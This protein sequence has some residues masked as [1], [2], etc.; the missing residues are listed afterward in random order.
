M[1]MPGTA[2][3]CTHTPHTTHTCSMMYEMMYEPLSV[4]FV[5]LFFFS[6]GFR[7]SC[8][9]AAHSALALF[10]YCIRNLK[11]TRYSSMVLQIQQQYICTMQLVYIMM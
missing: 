8:L 9:L 2:V 1:C 3:G 5:T 4:F 6:L 10:C 7:G 11:H